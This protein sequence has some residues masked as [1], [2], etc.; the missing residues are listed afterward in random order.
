MRTANIL[1]CIALLLCAGILWVQ[2]R[3]LRDLEG[4]LWHLRQ[5]EESWWLGCKLAG[6]NGEEIS[7][8]KRHIRQLE[9]QVQHRLRGIGDEPEEQP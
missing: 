4:R 7:V 3:Q 5:C 8:L 1:V 6:Q 2:Q 9:F